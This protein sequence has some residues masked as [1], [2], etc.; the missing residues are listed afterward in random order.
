MEINTDFGQV[1]GIAQQ[2]IGQAC[3][4]GFAAADLELCLLHLLLILANDDIAP[5]KEKDEPVVIS[6][7]DAVLIP[8]AEEAVLQPV[9]AGSP[10][11]RQFFEEPSPAFAERVPAPNLP[12]DEP[13]PPAA[14]AKGVPVQWPLVDAAAL[15]AALAVGVRVPWQLVG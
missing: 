6:P 10:G 8:P 15:S 1:L 7:A 12:V 9:V 14:L 4:L 5:A 13:V 2:G 3:A 11:P